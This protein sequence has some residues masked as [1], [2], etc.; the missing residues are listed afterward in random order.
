MIAILRRLLAAGLLAGLVA[1]LAVTLVQQAQ[2]VPLIL[3]AETYEEAG[4]HDHGTSDRGHA[5]VWAPADGLERL[6]FTLLANLVAGAGYGL[7]LVAA[8]IFAG[9]AAGARRGLLWG[10]AGFAAFALAPALGLPPEL[11]GM[12]SA[13]LAARQAWWLV[14]ALS[15]AGGLALLVFAPA[16]PHRAWL[17]PA[18]QV[19]GVVA[20]ALPHLA[21]APQPL[22]ETAS[23]VPAELAAQFAVA[24]LVAQ[25]AFWAVLGAVAGHVLGRSLPTLGR[26][27]VDPLPA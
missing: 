27:A 6:A 23:A 9:R 25:A 3:A 24:A 21:G 11:P 17:R 18:L 7:V 26:A 12:M 22:D 10:A 13:D 15:T 4:A 5:E 14:A 19:V 16:R 8:M 1:G 20:L 2:V